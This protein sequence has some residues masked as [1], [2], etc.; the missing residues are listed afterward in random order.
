MSLRDIALS[1]DSRA[2]QVIA[3]VNVV[4]GLGRPVPGAAVAAAWSGVITTGDTARSTD[5][6]G[7]ATFYSSRT[8]SPGTVNFCVGGVTAGGLDYTPGDN[9]ETC[10][11]VTK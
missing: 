9:L 2:T 11:A 5:A 6:T 1:L 4:D 3:R 7:T 8:R 10:D